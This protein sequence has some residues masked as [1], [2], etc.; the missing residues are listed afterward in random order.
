MIAATVDRS[1]PA[2][3]GFFFR[4]RDLAFW[5]ARFFPFCDFPPL[6][7][8]DDFDSIFVFDAAVF[9]LGSEA[10]KRELRNWL[11]GQDAA[12]PWLVAPAGTPFFIASRAFIRERKISI[13]PGVFKGLQT[14]KKAA[15]LVLRHP[16]VACRPEAD[17]RRI[18]SAIIDFQV[19]YLQKNG[20]HIEDYGRFYLAGLMPIGKNTRIA[21][22]VVLKGET[23]IG[24]NASIFPN[25]YIENSHIGDGCIILPGSV[26]CDSIVENNVQ[27]GP[28]CHLRNGSLVKK[29]AKIGNFVEMKKSLLGAGSK[30]MHLSYIG[31]ARV[32]KKVNIGAGTITCNYDGEKKN[33][34]IIGDHVF[35]GSGTEL[36]APVT[37]HNDAYVAAGSTITEN[38]PKNALAVARQRQRNIVDWVLRKRKKKT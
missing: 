13:K 15:P 16:Y 38:V 7:Q 22:G 24:K 12:E 27:L 32:G 1:R 5:L 36:V 23:T 35:I 20:V 29:G 37:I 33:S 34:T 28:Y 31:D 6:P 8:R 21:S 17:P 3:G 11:K 10:S 2:R 4:D 18:E 30:A 9:P 19:D 14:G 25:C 26:I